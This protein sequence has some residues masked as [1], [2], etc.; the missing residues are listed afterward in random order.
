MEPEKKVIIIPDS[1]N[2]AWKPFIMLLNFIGVIAW[3]VITYLLIM[4]TR[5]AMAVEANSTAYL[6]MIVPTVTYGILSLVAGTA[7]INIL[8][9]WFNFIDL[10]KGSDMSKLSG[11]II[12]V[13]TMISVALIIMGVR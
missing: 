11:A 7:L 10:M 4:E 12:W 1:V 5:S 3:V 8:N 2:P 6:G 13:G 9:P